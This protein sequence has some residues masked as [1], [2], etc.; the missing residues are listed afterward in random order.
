MPNKKHNIYTTFK[1][2]DTTP[3]KDTGNNDL[4]TVLGMKKK[5]TVKKKAKKK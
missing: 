2:M 4:Y 3:H 1:N 5:K